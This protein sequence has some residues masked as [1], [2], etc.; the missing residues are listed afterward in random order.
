MNTCIGCK[1]AAWYVTKAGQYRPDGNGRCKYQYKMPPL[2]VS[3][4]WLSKP[5]LEMTAIN[6]HIIYD[7]PC[8][9]YTPKVG[10]N[11]T[12]KKLEYYK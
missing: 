9:Y 3:M 4:Y 8:P 11:M 1:Y 7:E 6:R 12:I 10:I 2:P 5:K